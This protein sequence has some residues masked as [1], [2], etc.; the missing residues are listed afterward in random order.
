MYYFELNFLKI[1]VLESIF[2]S[3]Q[4]NKWLE[5]SVLK[6]LKNVL[7][8]NFGETFLISEHDSN[9]VF[10]VLSQVYCEINSTPFTLTLT[11]IF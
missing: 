6:S 7:L 4:I 5:M 1:A 10:I 9:E 2:G 11:S 8:V 3:C